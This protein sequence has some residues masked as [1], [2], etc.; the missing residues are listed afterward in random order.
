MDTW[1]EDALSALVSFFLRYCNFCL[2]IPET[3]KSACGVVYTV[4]KPRKVEEEETP[5]PA[6]KKVKTQAW[7]LN[8]LPTEASILSLPSVESSPTL[9]LAQ[10]L[11]YYFI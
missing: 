6:C 5:L 7:G 2:Y 1:N 11:P 9:Q 3:R 10:F 4:K 8:Q